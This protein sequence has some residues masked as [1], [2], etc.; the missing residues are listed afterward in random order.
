LRSVD[1]FE[2]LGDSLAHWTQQRERRKTNQPDDYGERLVEQLRRPPLA[3]RAVVN[4]KEQQ[5]HLV[6]PQQ[7]REV[8]REVGRNLDIAAIESALKKADVGVANGAGLLAERREWVVGIN[9][10]GQGGHQM[11]VGSAIVQLDANYSGEPLLETMRA[12]QSLSDY[13]DEFL[14]GALVE[15]HNNGVFRIELVVSGA[16]RDI[17]FPGNVAHGGLVEPALAEQREC[18]VE[19]ST[20][21]FFGLL[22][23][24]LWH[25]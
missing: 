4:P 10:A 1:Q 3:R 24:C 6:E 7:A 21:R 14:L 25:D 17:G 8:G 18:R 13:R 16:E 9:M 19:N 12:R 20:P 5:A 22:F 23:Y 15:S 11:A 2:Q